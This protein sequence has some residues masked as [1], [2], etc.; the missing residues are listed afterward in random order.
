MLLLQT[1][2]MSEH[3]YFS[4]ERLFVLIFMFK[5]SIIKSQGTKNITNLF[6]EAMLLFSV[7]VESFRFAFLLFV[8]ILID[9]SAVCWR[10]NPV[11][12]ATVL[13]II[14]RLSLVLT[15][16]LSKQNLLFFICFKV[17]KLAL[18]QIK[19]SLC[20]HVLH[21]IGGKHTHARTHTHTVSFSPFLWM[22][23]CK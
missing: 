21:A 10:C 16:I 2:L 23:N 13:F 4:Y 9:T 17:G 20:L 1:A 8:T 5:T 3:I 11:S 12:P 15:Y 22:T 7:A 18:C 14:G 6:L 19:L